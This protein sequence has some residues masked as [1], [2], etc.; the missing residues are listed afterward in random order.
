MNWHSGRGRIRL[1]LTA[2]LTALA[3]CL[4][5]GAALAV[6]PPNESN[7]WTEEQTATGPIQAPSAPSEAYN[8]NGGQLLQVWRGD[9]NGIYLSL[10][11][12]TDVQLG[13]TTPGIPAQTIAAPRVV[14][15]GDANYAIFQTGIDGQIWWTVIGPDAILATVESGST[16]YPAYWQALPG[17]TTLATLS[18]GVANAG[19]GSTSVLVTY[20]SSN[21]SQLYQQWW[22]GNQWLAPYAIRD[23]N[24]NSSPGVV[25]N[26]ALNVF[27]MFFRGTNS[28]LYF[29]IQPYGGQWSGIQTFTTGPS[30]GS[31]PAVNALSNGDMQIAFRDL[32]NHLWYLQWYHPETDDSIGTFSA[33]TQ[34]STNI[35]INTPPQLSGTQG[36]SI[37]TLVVSLGY[38]YWKLSMKEDSL[39]NNLTTGQLSAER[40]AFVRSFTSARTWKVSMKGNSLP[41]NLTAGQRADSPRARTSAAT[42]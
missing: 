4:P 33:F 10:A 38:V 30:V 17:T 5:A 16:Y 2:L 42:R 23:A 1:M 31:G 8:N 37:W 32:Q 25:W 7:Y 34:D 13:T 24:S 40:A 35:Q 19:P 12:G 29:A 15:Y 36:N 6:G 11:H 3:V 22:D 18:P 26:A 9:D 21:G 39:P 20:N 41:N 28:A 14:P 27:V